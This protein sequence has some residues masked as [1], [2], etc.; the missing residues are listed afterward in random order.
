MALGL[1]YRKVKGQKV[2]LKPDYRVVCWWG[3]SR[4]NYCITNNET[5]K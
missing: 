2:M 1:G 3:L 5:N 4:C